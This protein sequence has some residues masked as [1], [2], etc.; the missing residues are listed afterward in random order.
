MDTSI[1]PKYPAY[2]PDRVR[3]AVPLLGL[4]AYV[5]VP[6]TVLIFAAVIAGMHFVVRPMAAR[7]ASLPGGRA[8][9]REPAASGRGQPALA[10]AAHS[11]AAGRPG[12]DGPAYQ[13]ARHR[14]IDRGAGMEPLQLPYTLGD[15]EDIAINAAALTRQDI[16]ED[17][18]HRLDPVPGRAAGAD[19]APPAVA[20]GQFAFS[21]GSRKAG[22]LAA[23]APGPGTPRPCRRREP[24]CAESVGAVPGGR[25]PAQHRLLRHR[26]FGQDHN[27]RAFTHAIP[28]AGGW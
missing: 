22:E 3:S 25:V 8:A 12:H 27:L 1:A 5:S 17:V 21:I 20:D 10:A 24:A 6:A 14:L 4:S 16:A 11:R 7:Y 13:R 28:P 23:L 2:A 19:R 26:R 9:A 15:L 18:P